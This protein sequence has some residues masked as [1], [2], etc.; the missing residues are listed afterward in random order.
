MNTTSDDIAQKVF[1]LLTQAPDKPA[2]MDRDHAILDHPELPMDTIDLPVVGT[3]LTDGESPVEETTN[4]IT[5]RTCEVVVE[6]RAS[7]KHPIQG[8]RA[9]REWIIRTLTKDPRMGGLAVKIEYLGFKPYGGVLNKW[10]AG[11]LL[12]FRITYLWNTQTGA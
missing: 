4:L 12:T 5:R 2:G 6:V 9:F 1:D 3:Y 8:T 7:V 10:I 11:A